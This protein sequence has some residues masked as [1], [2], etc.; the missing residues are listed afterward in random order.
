MGRRAAAIAALLVGI[1]GASPLVLAS[2][3]LDGKTFSGVMGQ[4]GKTDSRPDD[5]VFKDGTFESTLCTTFGYG[6][7]EYQAQAAGD[8]VEFTAETT[9][10]DG[11]KMAWKGAVKGSDIEGTVLSMEQGGTS[12]ESWFKGTL[13]VN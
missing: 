2:G 9:S 10:T 3:A 6:T 1:L 4:K 13:K 11:G 7:G 5:F 8:A 12:S